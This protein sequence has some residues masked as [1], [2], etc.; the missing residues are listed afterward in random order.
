MFDDNSSEKY[1]ERAPEGF[2][3]WTV[4][5]T[6]IALLSPLIVGSIAWLLF[7]HKAWPRI[8]RRANAMLKPF[9]RKTH[10]EICLRRLGEECDC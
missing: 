8:A 2:K 7:Q 5:L 1:E 10:E 3:E 4:T 9:Q 6:R